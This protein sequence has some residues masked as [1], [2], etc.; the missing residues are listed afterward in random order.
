MAIAFNSWD[1]YREYLKP[2][3]GNRKNWQRFC[4]IE[5]CMRLQCLYGIPYH[6]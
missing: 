3:F 5:G 2:I 1:D 6:G 4:F